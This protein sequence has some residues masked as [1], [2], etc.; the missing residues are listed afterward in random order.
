MKQL[1]WRGER[2]FS[3]GGVRFICAFDDY[4]RKTDRNHFVILK[5]R[6][7]LDGYAAVFSDA[8]PR[9]ILEFGIFQGGSPVMFSLWFDL[10]KFVGVDVCAPVAEFDDFCARHE[11][12]KRIRSYYGVSQTD[13]SRIDQIVRKE[14]PN[15]PLDVVIDDASHVYRE[16]RRT[17]EI[18]F[19]H[20]RPGGTYVIE[21]WGWAHWPGSRFHPGRTA[22]SMLVMELMMV[23]ASRSDLISEVRVFP[24]FAFVTKSPQAL[25]ISDFELDSLYTKRGIELVGAEKHNL[26]GVSK[27]VLARLFDRPV[28]KLRRLRNR[29]RST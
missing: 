19:P 22:L 27:L 6:A 29:R 21:D 24:S 5:D 26:M 14:F 3:V 28:N 15:E 17:F 9:N 25:P 18:A 7:A 2:E 13:K 23:C 4:S 11:A 16:T 10:H 8:Q 12:G 1:E 20:L